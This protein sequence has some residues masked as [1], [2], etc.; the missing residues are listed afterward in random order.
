MRAEGMMMQDQNE[1]RTLE[2]LALFDEDRRVW[3]ATAKPHE[4]FCVSNAFDRLAHRR[5]ENDPRKLEDVAVYGL[6]R[7]PWVNGLRATGDYETP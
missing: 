1:W 4:V 7:R 2:L 3:I 5:V 6:V